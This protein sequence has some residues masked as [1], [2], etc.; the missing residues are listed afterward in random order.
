VFRR[1]IWLLVAIMALVVFGLM[2]FTPTPSKDG[3]WW[4]SRSLSGLF[5]DN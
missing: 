5:E 2:I 3:D 1:L 4:F